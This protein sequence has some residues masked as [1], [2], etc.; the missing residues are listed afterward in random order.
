MFEFTAHHDGRGGIRARATR[1]G[2]TVATYYVGA[3]AARWFALDVAP[4]SPPGI[5]LASDSPEDVKGFVGWADDR[6]AALAAC[7]A[8]A[9][10]LGS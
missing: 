5:L 10:G 2:A 7:R 6:G 1:D 3:W 4:E 9:E 8:H